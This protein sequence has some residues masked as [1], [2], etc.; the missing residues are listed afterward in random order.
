MLAKNTLVLDQQVSDP[1]EDF[2]DGLSFGGISIFECV[3]GNLLQTI[4][5]FF[6]MG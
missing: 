6:E 5:M 4:L 2:V 3:D 1:S